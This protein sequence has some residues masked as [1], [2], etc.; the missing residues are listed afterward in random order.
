MTNLTDLTNSTDL[1]TP[2]NPEDKPLKD[3]SKLVRRKSNGQLEKGSVLNPKGKPLGKLSYLTEM[4]NAIE[5]YAKLHNMTPAQVNL[6][7]YM[8]GTDEAMKGEYNFYRDHMDRKHG[9]PMQPLTGEDGGP[10][11]I[12]GVHISIQR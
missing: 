12:Q 4:N 9:R 7:L 3:S 1:T 5:E 11:K 10:I 8:K 2:A 6:K